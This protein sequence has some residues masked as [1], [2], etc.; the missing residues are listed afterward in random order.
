VIQ[1]IG[2]RAAKTKTMTPKT[3][4][5]LALRPLQTQNLGH[6]HKPSQPPRYRNLLTS[7]KCK[8]PLIPPPPTNLLKRQDMVAVMHKTRKL[9][10]EE[11]HLGA[12]EGATEIEITSGQGTMIGAGIASEEEVEGASLVTISLALKSEMATID[13]AKE[14]LGVGVHLALMTGIESDV[15]ATEEVKQNSKTHIVGLTEVPAPTEVVM[16]EIENPITGGEGAAGVTKANLGVVEIGEGL[17]VCAEV[18]LERAGVLMLG[19]TIAASQVSCTRV[20]RRRWPTTTPNTD[21]FTSKT[22]T[23][24]RR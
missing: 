18:R 20:S 4:S 24:S 7:P 1:R 5:R 11:T 16:G 17:A 19:A 15:A 13:A 3:T 21:S 6:K 10:G 12:M 14:D 2:M 23:F 22:R 9:E 8:Q